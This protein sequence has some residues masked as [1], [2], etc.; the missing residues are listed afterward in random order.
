MH[1]FS[2]SIMLKCSKEDKSTVRF[3]LTHIGKQ[4]KASAK[5]YIKCLPLK[6]KNKYQ[7]FNDIQIH[8]SDL[9]LVTYYP[10]QFS[11]CWS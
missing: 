10:G 3:Q 8:L 2:S 4:R 6:F 5:D 11:A 1:A 7:I 9:N